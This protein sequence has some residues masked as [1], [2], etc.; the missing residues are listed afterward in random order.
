LNI[1]VYS[2][3]F[4]EIRISLSV[5]VG[6]LQKLQM[7]TLMRN[8]IRFSAI[9]KRVSAL[10]YS[11]GKYTALFDDLRTILARSGFELSFEQ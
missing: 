4:A 8:I 6:E 2:P 7:L 9:N 11:K 10:F 3:C 5:Y 1:A